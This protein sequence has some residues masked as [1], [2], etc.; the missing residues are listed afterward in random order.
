MPSVAKKR[1]LRLSG[2]NQDVLGLIYLDSAGRDINPKLIISA[3]SKPLDYIF[4]H[5]SG[6]SGDLRYNNSPVQPVV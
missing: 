1:S 6:E 3:S 2:A 5:C 4:F